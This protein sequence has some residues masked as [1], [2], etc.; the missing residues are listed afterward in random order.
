MGRSRKSKK[1]TAATEQLGPD[2]AGW[3]GFP[4]THPCWSGTLSS[5]SVF[6]VTLDSL[7]SRVGDLGAG[8]LPAS[9]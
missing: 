3:P 8:T 5:V 4:Q 6:K 9:V 1:L 7:D 2:P